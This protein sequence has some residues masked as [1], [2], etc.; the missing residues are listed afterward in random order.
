MIEIPHFSALG[1]DTIF[2]KPVAEL[3]LEDFPPLSSQGFAGRTYSR[4]PSVSLDETTSAVS[5]SSNEGWCFAGF[6]WTHTQLM[7]V[8]TI[9]PPSGL[10]RI[11]LRVQS[12]Q[13]P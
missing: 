2:D 6:A 10:P 12:P 9:V 8:P 5:Y 3:E 13:L 4:F 11:L 1:V 7:I